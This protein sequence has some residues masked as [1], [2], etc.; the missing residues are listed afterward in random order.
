MRREGWEIGSSV[1]K[2]LWKRE[3]VSGETSLEGADYLVFGSL[4]LAMAK[5]EEKDLT[6]MSQTEIELGLM[7]LRVMRKIWPE[8]DHVKAIDPTIEKNWRQNYP[9][10][11]LKVPVDW[12]PEKMKDRYISK[13]RPA[14]R[15]L[16]DV[17]P[18][19]KLPIAVADSLNELRE[20][21]P[22]EYMVIPGFA[23]AYIGVLKNIPV[24]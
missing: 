1:V 11:P 12:T 6:R 7:V 2:T 13:T 21:P 3:R 10:T 16:R 22:D 24:R 19:G 4:Y 17:F 20:T 18:D 5:I 23:P 15:Q 9:V 14:L 8:F